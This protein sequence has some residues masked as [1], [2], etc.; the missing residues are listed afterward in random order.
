MNHDHDEVGKFKE[1]IQLQRFIITKQVYR[2]PLLVTGLFIIINEN[3]STKKGCW[4]NNGY[5]WLAFPR[6][7]I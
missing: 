2:T 3:A 6:M 5:R 1:P 7:K 4:H